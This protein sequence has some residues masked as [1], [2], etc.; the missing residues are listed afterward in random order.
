MNAVLSPA[1]DRQRVR[2]TLL[3]GRV[4]VVAGCEAQVLVHVHEANFAAKVRA[5]LGALKDRLGPASIAQWAVHQSRTVGT[6]EVLLDD[7]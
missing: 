4:F 6:L 5:A 7:V 3:R 1:T 2:S